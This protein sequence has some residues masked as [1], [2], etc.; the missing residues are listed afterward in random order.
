MAW[1]ASFHTALWIYEFKNERVLFGL[2]A[3]GSSAGEATIVIKLLAGFFAGTVGAALSVMG[4]AVVIVSLRTAV[5]FGLTV[6]VGGLA[7]LLL[8]P[9]LAG[10]NETISL[11][12]LFSI[13]QASVG[14]CLGHWLSTEKIN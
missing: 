10:W 9:L 4:C 12:L 6:F 8:Y 5:P 1:S 11:L 13:W 14:A 2:S 3:A 7:G